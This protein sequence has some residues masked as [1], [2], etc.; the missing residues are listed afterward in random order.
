MWGKG[1]FSD[2]AAHV[3]EVN[4]PLPIL[5]PGAILYLLHS[6]LYSF[7]VF[8]LLLQFLCFLCYFKMACL[9]FI[10]KTLP[11]P[12]KFIGISKRCCCRLGLL[13]K[14]TNFCQTPPV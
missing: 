3:A 8:F 10:L 12:L 4:Q 1:S 5:T 9:G 11:L 14:L 7:D 2:K 6:D 13:A